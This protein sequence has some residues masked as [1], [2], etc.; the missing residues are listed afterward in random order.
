MNGLLLPPGQ[1]IL[2]RE[3]TSKTSRNS[4]RRSAALSVAHNALTFIRRSL[5]S[6]SVLRNTSIFDCGRVSPVALLGVL[7]FGLIPTA[8][9]ELPAPTLPSPFVAVDL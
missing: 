4:S 2:F 8:S 9:A 5:Q 7:L 6:F 3:N 1:G